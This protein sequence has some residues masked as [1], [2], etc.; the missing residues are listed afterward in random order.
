[1]VNVNEFIKD[2][3][4]YEKTT[5][6]LYWKKNGIRRRMDR[7]AGGIDKQGYRYL[8]VNRKWVN[9]AHVVWFIEKGCLPKKTMDHINGIR[10]DN[11]ISNLRDVTMRDNAT[12][13]KIH[14]EGRLPGCHFC[15]YTKKWRAQIKINGK[16][17]CLGRYKTESAAHE[18]YT[19]TR[20]ELG[21]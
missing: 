3:L 18:A 5:G 13:T 16:R 8:F 7:E 21:L 15:N 6:K 9:A 17:K 20:M 4:R 10:S 11:R 19:K 1:M 14:R 12:N 2:N